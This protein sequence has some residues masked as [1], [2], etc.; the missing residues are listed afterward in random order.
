VKW[1]S[2]KKAARVH[3]LQDPNGSLDGLDG[4]N[5]DQDGKASR[6]PLGKTVIGR[7]GQCY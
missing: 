3:V 7:L 1:R 2:E 6:E 4:D 5:S